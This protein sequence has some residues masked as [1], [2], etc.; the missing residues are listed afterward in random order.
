MTTAVQ[1][2]M[3]PVGVLWGFR[4][5]DEMRDQGARHLFQDAASLGRF[6]IA[7]SKAGDS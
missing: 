4:S 7:A 6:L 3:I 5:E 1:A 2:G